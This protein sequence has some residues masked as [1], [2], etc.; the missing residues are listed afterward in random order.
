MRRRLILEQPRIFP[1]ALL[2]QLFLGDKSESGGV[3][4]V[5][6]ARRLRAV[7]EEM[8]QMRVAILASHFGT[9][10]VSA[11]VFLLHD[12]SGL[13]GFGETRPS[14]ARVELVQ[15]TEQRL[16][17]YHVHVDALPIVVPVLV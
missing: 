6:Q 1:V 8:P 9:H 14:G 3:D 17:G 4:A 16:A 12:V 2:L 5:A 10:R 15:G 7:R 13:E 11:R